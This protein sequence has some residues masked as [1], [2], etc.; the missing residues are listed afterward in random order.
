MTKS[1]FTQTSDHP[2]SPDHHLTTDVT[3]GSPYQ[4]IERLNPI[5]CSQKRDMCAGRPSR[6][7]PAVNPN[8]LHQ[9]HRAVRGPKGVPDRITGIETGDAIP[10]DPGH[11]FAATTRVS[12]EF[13]NQRKSNAP[14]GYEHFISLPPAYAHD[15]SKKW[16]LILFLHGSGESQRSP[17]ESY[18]SLRHGI[19]KVVL[20]Y[21]KIRESGD[22]LLPHIDIPMAERTR[23]NKQTKQGDRSSEPVPSEGCTLLAENYLTVTPSLD[24]RRGY[25]WS[26]AILSVLLDEVLDR[27]RIDPD[28]IHLTGF[29]MGGYGVWDLALREP[30]RFAS[31]MPICGGADPSQADKLKHLPIWIHHGAKD[32]IIPAQA[33]VLMYDALLASGA[34]QLKFTCDPD[35]M[36]DAWTAAYNDTQVYRWMLDHRRASSESG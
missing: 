1:S 8:S 14:F 12:F 17:G 35:L 13:Y 24:M 23:K 29:S 18:A 6:D 28:R 31:L 19:P 30:H 11:P 21:D 32:D 16:P 20:C 10:K 2:L 27:Y 7:D 26:A 5:K 33:S 36:H 4:C 22:G 9:F 34:Q 15:V 3:P 25:G